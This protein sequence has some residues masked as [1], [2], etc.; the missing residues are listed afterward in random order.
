[1]NFELDAVEGDQ[2]LA[3]RFSARPA[4]DS[5]SD[6]LWTPLPAPSEATRRATP[7][8]RGD[9]GLREAWI[10]TDSP[11]TWVD[12][13]GRLVP[14]DNAAEAGRASVGPTTRRYAVMAAEL[15]ASDPA[16]DGRSI[17]GADYA[18]ALAKVAPCH[19]TLTGSV[20]NRVE[21]FVNI[22]TMQGIPETVAEEGGATHTLGVGIS[23]NGD[24]WAAGGTAP[25]TRSSGSKATTTDNS[26]HT[27]TNLVDYQDLT[28]QCAGRYE[29][30]PWQFADMLTDN[31]HSLVET[32]YIASCGNH[33]PN[34]T[35][36]TTSATAATFDGGVDLGPVSV[37]AQSGY[38]SSENLHY[39]FNTYGEVCGNSDKGPLAVT[40]VCRR[41]GSAALGP[42]VRRSGGA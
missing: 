40:W 12:P 10:S 23:V 37:S 5:R 11:Q 16:T 32:W 36:D 4:G 30:D 35:W 38:K 3:Y 17:G 9:L 8:F 34:D 22:E 7:T 42:A 33:K 13:Q 41:T 25:I 31:G 18:R 1:M 2:T 14:R 6:S 27:E 20:L 15:G 29:K 28:N 26:A 21:H 39:Q 19:I 24:G